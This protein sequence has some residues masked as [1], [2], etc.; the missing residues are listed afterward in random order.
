MLGEPPENHD[1]VAV[2]ASDLHLSHAAPVFRGNEFS[3]S[4][5]QSR[6]LNQV[7][8]LMTRYGV[9]LLVAGD[10]F[11]RWNVP[12]EMVSFALH[13]LPRCYA[14]PG[15]HDLP[16]HDYKLLPR[17]AFHVLAMVG[18]VTLLK[19]GEVTEVPGRVPL[20]LHGFAHGV[21]PVPCRDPHDMTLEVAVVHK[22][23]WTKSTGYDGA[24]EDCRV[25]AYEEALKGY[26]CA[27][28]GDNHI[29]ILK[30]LDNGCT[31]F[32]AGTLLRRTSK[33][34][35]YKPCVGLLHCDGSVTREYLDTSKDAVPD[36]KEAVKLEGDSR[37]SRKLVEE[38]LALGDT[39]VDFGE[40]LRRA[41]ESPKVWEKVRARVLK[42]VE[43][44]E[45]KK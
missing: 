21:P 38:L 35:D 9:P 13:H 45:G 15:N 24:P 20:R 10:V 32:N 29:S 28:F 30:K 34:R 16:Y 14:V 1:V 5:A 26:D 18:L 6:T 25:S 22:Y 39:D 43:S 19:P 23:V 4:S 33:E 31:L 40:A 36:E 42:A 8:A 2:L 37:H 44:W 12:P 11:D 17:S 3:W 41:V 7:R 27:L